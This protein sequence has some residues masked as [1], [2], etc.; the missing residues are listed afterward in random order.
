MLLEEIDREGLSTYIS[1]VKITSEE[2]VLLL[3]V[4]NKVTTEIP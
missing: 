1:T 3:S 4:Y 2:E